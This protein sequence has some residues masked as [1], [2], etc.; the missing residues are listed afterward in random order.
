MIIED[1]T[2][3]HL[4]VG[5]TMNEAHQNPSLPF[6]LSIRMNLVSQIID[7]VR[8]MGKEAIVKYY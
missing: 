6:D 3:L 1:C 4:F 7:T 8:K 2:D 5:R